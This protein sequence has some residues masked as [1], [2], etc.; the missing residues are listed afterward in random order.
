M[1]FAEGPCLQ[2]DS[3]VGLKGMWAQQGSVLQFLNLRQG[4]SW[5]EP[6]ERGSFPT[7]LRFDCPIFNQYQILPP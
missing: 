7:P 1:T 2:F 5:G 4:L 6:L 3:R